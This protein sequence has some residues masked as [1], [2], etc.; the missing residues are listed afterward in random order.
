[1]LFKAWIPWI[2]ASC[3]TMHSSARGCAN[4][5]RPLLVTGGLFLTLFF[6]NSYLFNQDVAAD[7][8]PETAVD[9]LHHEAAA[10]SLASHLYWIVWALVQGEHSLIAFDYLDYARTRLA[11]YRR[12]K[13]VVFP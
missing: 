4:T 7:A 11:E 5:W 9:A 2:T 13:A 6:C 1:M 3:L 10:Y 12:R 8:V